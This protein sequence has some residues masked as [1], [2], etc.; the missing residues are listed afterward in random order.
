MLPLDSP[1]WKNLDGS[2][3]ATKAH[4]TIKKFL[5]FLDSNP[6]ERELSIKFSDFEATIFDELF[7]QQNTWTATSAA[8]PYLLNIAKLLGTDDRGRLLYSCGIFHLEIQY[9]QENDLA[10]WYDQAISNAIDATIEFVQNEPLTSQQQFDFL[11]AIAFLDGELYVYYA[12]R[13]WEYFDTAC[14]WC[15]KPV[16]GF[17]NEDHY[18]MFREDE[19]DVDFNTGQVTGKTNPVIPCEDIRAASKLEKH[20]R[21]RLIAQV[22]WAG[23][24]ESFV[25]W[26]HQFLGTYPC[27]HCRR[28]THIDVPPGY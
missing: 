5:Q 19:G 15:E 14:L 20:Q 11:G 12:L 24:H 3:G 26:L 6:T 23:K 7:H 28:P 13:E 16:T 8:M 22:A 10:E 1:R 27:P 21:Y 18:V 9:P 2:Y 17:W 25:K 4:E